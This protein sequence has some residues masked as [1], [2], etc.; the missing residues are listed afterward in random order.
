M[1]HPTCIVFP[2]E[3]N[4][5]LVRRFLP[6]SSLWQHFGSPRS[7]FLFVG[8]FSLGEDNQC[9]NNVVDNYHVDNHCNQQDHNDHKHAAWL[10]AT[11]SI[12]SVAIMNHMIITKLSLSLPSSLSIWST[13]NI[14][15]AMITKL[16]FSIWLPNHH[17]P[18]YKLQYNCA[19]RTWLWCI[20]TNSSITPT[21]HNAAPVLREYNLVIMMMMMMVP[22][23][24][25]MMMQIM[26]IDCS[27]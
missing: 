25:M 14:R 16:S 4:K 10:S 20:E 27:S 11:S 12:L 3:D 17:R 18:D 7:S 2:F 13:I 24:I 23:M 22:F 9:E 6:L 5:S 21:S 1:P 8:Y 26:K 19:M 15:M